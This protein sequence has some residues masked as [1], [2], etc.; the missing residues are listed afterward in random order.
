MKSLMGISESEEI[1]E[2][3]LDDEICETING[4]KVIVAAWVKGHIKDSHT[5]FGKGSVFLDNWQNVIPQIKSAVE[6]TEVN[7]EQALYTTQTDSVTG[8]DLVLRMEDASN[9]EGANETTAT[10]Q[11]GPNNVEVPAIETSEPKENF[12]TNVITLVIRPTTDLQYVP[13]PLK[14]EVADDIPNGTVYSLL[15]SWPG[16]GD[17]PRASEWNGQWAVIIPSTTTEEKI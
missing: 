7:P 6:N 10:K 3:S 5:G 13:E 2:P 15:S 17:V 16:S 14:A 12:E 1:I 4:V 11:E 8:Y 9:L